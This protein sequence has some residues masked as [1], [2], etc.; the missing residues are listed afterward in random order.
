MLRPRRFPPA[1]GLVLAALAVLLL[2]VPHGGHAPGTAAAGQAAAAVPA[3]A[4][5]AAGQA[6]GHT[7]AGQ[8][9]A[10][11]TLADTSPAAP[12]GGLCSVPGIRDIGGGAGV[13]LPGEC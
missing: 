5:A 2:C 10:A 4:Q 12:S 9:I 1:T 3:A 7:A 11:Q 8:P 6:A 13:C